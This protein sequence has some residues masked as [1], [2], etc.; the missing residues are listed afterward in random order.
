MKNVFA[1][2]FTLLMSLPA[3]AGFRGYNGTTDLK[4]F[5]SIKCSSGLTCTNAGKGKMAI[6]NYGANSLQNRILAT[7]TT[8]VASQCGSTFYNEGAVEIELPEASAVQ[9]CRLTFV[10]NTAANFDIDPDAADKILVQTD[11]A[12]DKIRNA[13]VGN[14]ITIESSSSSA[15]TP[16]AVVGTWSDA[17]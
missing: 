6:S 13:T 15:W 7:A 14:S 12:G 9:G 17:N 11:T 4:N 10:T 1:L 3:L 16:I 5:D 2:L 8:I